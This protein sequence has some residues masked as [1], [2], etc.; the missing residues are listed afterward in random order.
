MGGWNPGDKEHFP[1]ICNNEVWSSQDGANWT[2]VKPNTFLDRDF[3]AAKDWEGRHT[4]GYVVYQDKMWIIGGDVNQGNYQND[5]WNTADGKAWTLV[6]N[7]VPWSPRAL[8]YTLIFQNKIWVLGGQ[9]MP[10]SLQPKKFSIAI[11]GQQPTDSIGSKSR[12]RS[13]TGRRGEWLAAAS[14]FRDGSGG[15]EVAPTTLPRPPGETSTTTCGVRQMESTGSSTSNMRRGRPGSITMSRSST[16]ACG[17]WKDITYRMATETTSGIH[18]TGRRGKSCVT[19]H[20]SRDTPP[21]CSFTI[22][23]S[24]GCRK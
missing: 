2:L 10:A 19:R 17:S 7:S 5:V 13:R 21:V 4:A 1:R 15:S 22:M 23:L 11:S 3:D 8:H 6:T 9:T 12:R 16:T 24:D 18:Q 14:C 20:G